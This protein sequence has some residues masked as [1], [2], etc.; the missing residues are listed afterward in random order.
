MP[1]AGFA[2]N[3]T[4]QSKTTTTINKERLGLQK[5]RIRRGYE[6]AILPHQDRLAWSVYWTG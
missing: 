2:D 3:Q 5:T 4:E 6:L 1:P